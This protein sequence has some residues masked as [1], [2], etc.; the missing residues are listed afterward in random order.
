MAGDMATVDIKILA[1]QYL[2][3]FFGLSIRLKSRAEC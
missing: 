2:M 3:S 1:S